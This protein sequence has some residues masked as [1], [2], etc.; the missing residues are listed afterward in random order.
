MEK[1]LFIQSGNSGSAEKSLAVIKGKVFPG[2]VQLDYLADDVHPALAKTAVPDLRTF[3]SLQKGILQAT[4]FLFRLWQTRYDTVVVMFTRESGFTKH[5]LLALLARKGNL[6]IF[7]ENCDCFHYSHKKMYLH[8]RW[9]W[10]S[11]LN[12]SRSG[13][14]RTVNDG[15]KVLR[16][17]GP[18]TFLNIC[19]HRLTTRRPVKIQ[20]QLRSDIGPLTFP[21][22]ERPSV[23]IVI[24]VYN[25]ILYTQN[26]LASIL[27]QTDDTAYEVIVVDDKSTDQTEETLL[28]MQNLHYIRAQENRGFVGSCNAGAEAAR[29]DYILFL[30]N[31]TTVTPGW[32]SA[33]VR[34]LDEDR[35]CGAVGAK[36]VYPDG[37]LQEA[38]G[39]IWRD[40]S[41]WNYG[42]FD[43]ASK[44]EYCYLR[45][46]DYCSGAAL[47]VRKNLFEQLGGFD[48]RYAP[49]Y[50][51]DTDLCFS[52]RKL[53][54]RVMFQPESVVVH[55]EGISAGTSISSG[56]K[57]YQQINTAKFIEKWHHELAHQSDHDVNNI[58][59]ARDRNGGK[60][61]LV[62]DH[63]VPT[64]D[65]DAGSFFMF[66]LL[67]AL[68]QQ[69]YRV[70]FWPDNLHRSEPYTTLLQRMGV[71]VI[72]GRHDFNEYLEKHHTFFDAAIL[73]RNHIAINF[74]DAVRKK[75]QKVIYHDPDLEFLREQ[76][77]V[78]FEGGLED[79]L[80]RIK[81][82]EFHLFRNCDIIG[83]HSPVERDIIREELHDA[84]VAVIPLPINRITAC[85]TP[86]PDRAGLLFV[87][88]THPPNIDALAY[89]LQ[90][91][92]PLVLARLPELKLY[93]VGQVPKAKLKNYA[94]KNVVF[95]GFVEDLLP[96][97]EEARLYVAPLRYG[98]GI[99]GKILEAL[100]F[101][102]PVVTTSIGSEGIG[103]TNGKNVLIEDD[104]A[105]FADAVVKLYQDPD[106]WNGM[107]VSGQEHV[108]QNFSQVI[109]AEKVQET[110]S[111]LL[112]Q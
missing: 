23:S 54:Y 31:D 66:S 86:F 35:S 48:Q 37:T 1:V 59:A 62:I 106:L 27:E 68:A 18:R 80:Q 36:L 108:E 111:K 84:E 47:M 74:I 71:E 102:L 45:E 13:V 21:F 10:V 76:R 40:A 67:K 82:R 49:A 50:W 96:Y 87:G 57:R 73:T 78:A 89:F 22:F 107:R 58:F 52:I 97:F 53:G 65:K 26:C 42:K 92:F 103:L 77:R 9:R 55:Y 4:L 63:Y 101:G 38:G 98:A 25:K 11:Y 28:K 30:N 24:P 7:N 29:G 2:D 83:I 61:I 41:G 112:G 109:F 69:G 56:M 51:E 20:A 93:I 3:I 44:P 110:L 5:K 12:S 91:I 104:P 60:R 70:V 81:E 100:S 90:D 17:E 88:S 34:P 105:G 94:D 8:L 99:K 46:V 72:Y 33:L 79:E 75:I 64:Y 19:W 32:L 14:L 85:A 43:D 6:L 39:I 15:I 16:N 95:T